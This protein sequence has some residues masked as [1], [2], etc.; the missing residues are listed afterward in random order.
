MGAQKFRGSKFI[1]ICSWHWKR[2]SGKWCQ[3]VHSQ[4]LFEKQRNPQFVN[5]K[6]CLKTFIQKQQRTKLYHN[7]GTLIAIQHSHP[8]SEVH[9]ENSRNLR[10]YKNLLHLVCVNKSER[11]ENLFGNEF[12]DSR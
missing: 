3:D 5:V 11:Y 10:F 1:K 8:G 9:F 6:L 2:C 7:I 4:P 12:L